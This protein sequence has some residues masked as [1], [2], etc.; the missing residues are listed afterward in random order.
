M[1][2]LEEYEKKRER[3]L[4]ARGLIE[5]T[6]EDEMKERRHTK[7]YVLYDKFSTKSISFSDNIDQMEDNR[8]YSQ[9]KRSPRLS[10]RLPKL[11]T[12]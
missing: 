8:D 5:K 11:I 10:F 3:N 6:L 4:K 7:K 2:S 12:N 1:E 9:D